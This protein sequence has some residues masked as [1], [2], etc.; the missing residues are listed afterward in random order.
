MLNLSLPLVGIPQ[1][2][3]YLI[4]SVPLLVTAVMAVRNLGLSWASIGL[5]WGRVPFQ[6]LIALSGLILGYIEYSILQP[7]P[8]AASLTWEEAA[9]PALILL[10]S[11]GF[12]EELVFRG[13]MQRVAVRRLGRFGFIYVAAVFAILH[14][15]H[16]SALDILFVF[17]VA[18]FFGWVVVRTRSLLGVTLAHGLT[19]IMLFLVVPYSLALNPSVASFELGTPVPA[20]TVA[21]PAAAAS[22]TLDV[23][24]I[25]SGVAL[26]VTH[27][28]A[29]A[30]SATPVPN[31]SSP[32]AVISP[33][34]IGLATATPGRT[35][36][37]R[38][39]PVRN[40]SFELTDGWTEYGEILAL[41]SDE[42]AFDGEWSMHLGVPRDSP[43]GY[44]TSGAGQLLELPA[45]E[46]V[47]ATLRF[48]FYV[49]YDGAPAPQDEDAQYALI[50]DERG[51][52]QAEVM[53][54]SYGE[55]SRGAWLDAGEFD[56]SGYTWPLRVHFEVYNDGEWGMTRMYIDD[57]RVEV[58]MSVA[59][60]SAARPED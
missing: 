20:R 31:A 36:I 7:E 23:G 49:Q 2:Y 16:S 18:L 14:I 12:M 58:Y 50:L 32:P 11:T 25:A 17:A 15:G 3:W 56:L 34:P 1:V 43:N 59:T 45:G 26:G 46:V 24:P 54:F 41:R 51:Q 40:H 22:G 57:V 28:S 35:P 13:V 37:A 29:S 48:R 42:K 6:L 10:V 27:D 9:I 52:A 19:N 38:V 39:D 55:C 47:S 33:T 44:G 4:I 60:R 53:R 5:N 21:A 30:S 8:L